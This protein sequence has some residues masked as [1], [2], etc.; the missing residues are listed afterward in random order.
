MLVRTIVRSRGKSGSNLHTF[1]KG[2]TS[3]LARGCF[4]V[5]LDG[6]AGRAS[7]GRNED[8]H[9]LER[10][11]AAAESYRIAGFDCMRGTNALAI[12]VNSAP[13]DG[14]GRGGARFV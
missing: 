4:F 2:S 11:G 6:L 1:S 10:H 14:L 8:N 9:A 12:E 5:A 13:R 3:L 7:P